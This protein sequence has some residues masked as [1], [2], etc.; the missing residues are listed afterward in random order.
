[1][2]ATTAVVLVLAVRAAGC[3]RPDSAPEPAAPSVAAP[4]VLH[5]PAAWA[6]EGTERPGGGGS[7]PAA[8]VTAVARRAVAAYIG[9][10]HR[11]RSRPARALLG[12]TFSAA[13]TRQLVADPPRA[14][15]HAVPALRPLVVASEG[16]RGFTAT[17]ITRRG[18]LYL[19][20][21]LER[22]RGRLVVTALG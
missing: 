22:I 13:I 16:R 2:I 14:P 21:W 11:P 4:R 19:V 12:Q 17:A 3:H 10:E 6:G 15:G 20:L 9:F 7:N 8:S 18:E 1:M 5:R